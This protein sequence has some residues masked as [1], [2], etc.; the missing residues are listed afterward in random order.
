[1]LMGVR[2]IALSFDRILLFTS[3]VEYLSMCLFSISL[4]KCL[5]RPLDHLHYTVDFVVD[6]VLGT[7]TI[8]SFKDLFSLL[9]R[10][11]SCSLQTHLKRTLDSITDV[12]EPP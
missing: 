9:I 7:S 10:I 8:L 1:M 4:E 2:G 5:F 11:Y 6:D 12:S 3:N